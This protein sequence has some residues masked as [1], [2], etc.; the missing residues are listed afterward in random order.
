MEELALEIYRQYVLNIPQDN[1][2]EITNQV[3]KL[4]QTQKMIN[5]EQMEENVWQK[6]Q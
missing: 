2:R 1:P 5:K 6:D 3:L 4:W